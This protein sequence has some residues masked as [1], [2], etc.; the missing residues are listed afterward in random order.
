MDEFFNWFAGR[1]QSYKSGLGNW[2]VTVGKVWFEKTLGL[3]EDQVFSIFWTVVVVASWLFV[4]AKIITPIS[5]RFENPARRYSFR[6]VSSGI[7]TALAVVLVIG[8][9]VDTGGRDVLGFFA[10]ISAGLA[11]ALADPITNLAGWLFILVREPFHVRDRIEIGDEIK[12]DVID[13]RMFMFSLLEVGNWVDAE[14][15]TGR[16]VH[17]PNNVVFKKHIANYTQGFQYIWNEIPIIVT[18]ESN[19]EN[20]HQILTGIIEA[21]SADAAA[22][23]QRQVH[24]TSTRFMVYYRRFTPIVW[25]SV[26][27]IGVKLTMRYL[28]DARRRRSTEHLIW[29]DVL[30]AFAACDD[31]DFA[32]PTERRFHN[33]LEGKPLAGGPA[34]T[35]PAPAAARPADVPLPVAL[36]TTPAPAAPVEAETGDVPQIPMEE[37]PTSPVEEEVTQSGPLTAPTLDDAPEEAET[38]EIPELADEDAATPKTDESPG[39]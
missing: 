17:I 22:S 26:G 5:R 11:I 15:S 20:A 33:H 24:E 38:G 37:P 35:T 3:S 31:I 27:D 12:G 32:Y 16:I 4:R 2:W 28:C 25:V 8:I 6:K 19:W 39:T 29:Q 9:W 36:G 1:F 14:Q 23:A 7:A 18:F 34:R 30:R 10:L 21:Q 13:I